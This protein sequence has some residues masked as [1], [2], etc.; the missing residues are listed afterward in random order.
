[1]EG[2]LSRAVR[3]AG[4]APQCVGWSLAAYQREHGLDDAAVAAWLGCPLWQLPRLALC[5]RPVVG[6]QTFCAEVERLAQYVSCDPN[7]LASLIAAAH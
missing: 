6:S 7:R 2:L 4:S 1:M 3:W 5:S